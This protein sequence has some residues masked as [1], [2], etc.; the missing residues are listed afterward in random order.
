MLTLQGL[1]YKHDWLGIPGTEARNYL[2]LV[3]LLL[4]DVSLYV[5]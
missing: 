1:S 3:S 5:L 4:S 2:H